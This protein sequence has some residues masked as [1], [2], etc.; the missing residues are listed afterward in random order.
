MEYRSLNLRFTGVSPLL[1]HSGQMVDPLNP[2]IV[3]MKFNRAVKNV[4]GSENRTDKIEELAQRFEWFGGLWV[5]RRIGTLY[6]KDRGVLAEEDDV[7]IPANCK[8]VVPAHVIESCI[9]CGATKA[10]KGRDFSAAAI[11]TDDALFEHDGPADLMEL[12]LDGQYMHRCSAVIGKS[13]VMRVRPMFPTWSFKFVVQYDPSVASES[14]IVTAAT[15]A[16]HRVGIG[17][18]RPGAPKGGHWGRFAV[19]V[20]K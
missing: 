18:W 13:R 9:R 16:G 4:K 12:Y 1:M 19:E 15:D 20:L 5:N 11:V 2:A 14:I 17:D 7:V 8:I 3:S 6:A 10:K